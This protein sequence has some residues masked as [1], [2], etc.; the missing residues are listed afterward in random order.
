MS[1]S[2]LDFHAFR[3]AQTAISAYYL[4]KLGPELAYETPVLGV[5]WSIPFEFPTFQGL[6]ALIARYW[7][8]PMDQIG[9]ATSLFFSMQA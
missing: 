8:A 5:P 2:V 3:Q 7:V 4:W 9:R 6:V 1:N